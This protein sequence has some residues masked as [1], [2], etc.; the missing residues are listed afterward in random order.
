[1]EERLSKLHDLYEGH[2]QLSSA[3]ADWGARFAH[4]MHVGARVKDCGCSRAL[5]DEYERRARIRR[6]RDRVTRAV[7]RL[8]RPLYW[9]VGRP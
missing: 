2:S 8:L 5:I 1:M 6:G 7:H 4:G 9:A 3:A